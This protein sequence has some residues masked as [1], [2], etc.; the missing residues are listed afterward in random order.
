LAK[1][2]DKTSAHA[3][4]SRVELSYDGNDKLIGRKVFLNGS[5][6]PSEQQVFI[7]ENGQIVLEFDKTGGGAL[8]TA[9]LAR[10]YLWGPTVDQLLA[11]EDV[12]SLTDAELNQVRWPLTD[13]LGT[14]R[15]WISSSGALLDHAE[16]DSFG[17]RM[18]TDAIDAA[19]EWTARY[20]DPLTGLQYNDGRWYN[21]A[22]Q[23]WMSEDP[24]GFAGGDGN[25]GRYVGNSPTLF[26][27]PSGLF[28][29]SAFS[30][31][32]AVAG[33][34]FSVVVTTTTTVITEG[35]LPTT[36]QIVGAAVNG[37]ITGGMVGALATGDVCTAATIGA[38][39]GALGGGAGNAVQQLIDTGRIDPNQVTTAA[40]IG[41][42][43]GA[44]S[45]GITTLRPGGPVPSTAVVGGGNRVGRTA[46][47]LAL[48]QQAL[49]GAGA[50]SIGAMGQELN[51]PL[52]ANVRQGAQTP[53][54]NQ[55]NNNPT[56]GP[57]GFSNPHFGQQMHQKFP[58]VLA[59]QTDTKLS[60]WRFRV[61]PGQTGVDAEYQGPR[62]RYPGFK[63]AEL[64]PCTEN[65]FRTFLDQL[66]KWLLP[67]NKTQL[68]WY[69][70]NGTIFSSGFKY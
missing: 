26:V 31:I 59:K 65:G 62:A 60:D 7:Y 49:Q 1:V 6:T 17:R 67:F 57:P 25:L 37:A 61:K 10:R 12:N 18:D 16:Y 24:I 64:K 36:G 11:D 39:G 28:W 3:E 35:R 9:D 2:T 32:G 45:G 56:Q 50:G 52:T 15:D 63:Y 4:T 68:W 34:F 46:A 5:V 51:K 22:I 27:D 38:I 54:N 14:P 40:I 41:G 30:G 19:F 33:A 29:G 8:E 55:P 70:E 13:H 43:L 66:R 21:P 23:R 69:D 20:G 58:S 48:Q 53:Q 47:E 44:A 42:V